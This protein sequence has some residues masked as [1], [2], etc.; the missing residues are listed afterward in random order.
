MQRF[1]NAFTDFKKLDGLSILMSTVLGKGLNFLLSFIIIALLSAD[2]YGQAI[3]A[4]NI[5]SFAMPFAGF[6]AY[7]GILRFGALSK[8]QTDKKQLFFY[9]LKKG[10][11]FSLVVIAIFWGLSIYFG[12]KV[13][14][15]EFLI[16]I[17]SFQ[18]LSFTIFEAIKSYARI[19]HLNK[20]YAGMELMLF[21]IQFVVGIALGY[22]FG[23]QGY[24]FAL[25]ISPILAGIYYY[26][27]LKL[28]QATASVNKHNDFWKHSIFTSIS[29]I[30]S[31]LLYL[32]DIFLIGQ[33]IQEATAE[34][35][36]YYKAATLIPFN[37]SFIPLAYIHATFVKVTQNTN[38]KPALAGFL[39]NYFALFLPLGL[40]L[41]GVLYFAGDF[42]FEF[43]KPEYRI[44]VPAY[45]Y[46][47]LGVLG[48]FLLRV[49]F[50]NLLSAIGKAQWNT[51]GSVIILMINVVANYF[52][53]KFYGITG[54]AMTT[55]SLLWLSGIGFALA[56][57]YWFKKK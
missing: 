56:F 42:I 7:Q 16:R 53:I 50:G 41:V 37:L 9:G 24:L 55:A 36:A 10:I 47:C 20:T 4:L 18:I 39:K 13:E 54:A 25:V 23:G 49:P 21:C 14:N 19:H 22:L 8:S 5:V 35:I 51:T 12:T 3:Y 26:F 31:Q 27:K 34:N 15:G 45:Q 2:E 44:A 40:A 46:L 43:V 30:A 32:I 52:A 38:N 48:T 57:F 11:Q 1:I 6:G 28:T 29:N 17:I 33:V